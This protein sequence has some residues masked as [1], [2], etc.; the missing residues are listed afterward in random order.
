MS[1]F[2]VWRSP[3]AHL[4]WDQGV[5]GSNPCTPT[6][7]KGSLIFNDPFFFLRQLIYQLPHIPAQQFTWRTKQ[8][9]N[10]SVVIQGIWP[11]VVHRHPLS[12]HHATPVAAP[13]QHASTMAARTYQPPRP[14]I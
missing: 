13:D 7:L 11:A 5:Q 6:S 10:K 4:V 14:I 12:L 3:V 9:Q 1:V 2:G 8:K